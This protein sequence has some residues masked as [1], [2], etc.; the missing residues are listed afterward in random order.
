MGQVV[1]SVRYPRTQG[2]LLGGVLNNDW[3]DIALDASGR[4]IVADFGN[5]TNARKDLALH[6]IEEP[7]PDEG[8]AVVTRTVLF[9]YPEQA[10]WP[11]PKGDFNYDAEA[12]FT[13][14]DEVYVL[15]KHRSD[16]MSRLYR[17]DAR[18]VGVVNV[19]TRVGEFDALGQVTGADA[20]EDGLMLA[21]LTYDRI[22]VFERGSVGE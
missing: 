1:K 4:L 16:T 8:R 9:R 11:A 19:L 20:S 21:V 12:L 18:E 3:E 14:G 2:L 7:E 13:V 15:S 22:F 10:R 6:F 5:N 17:L